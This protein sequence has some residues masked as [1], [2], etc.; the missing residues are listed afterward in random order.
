MDTEKRKKRLTRLIDRMNDGQ[1]AALRDMRS[2]LLD[3]QFN[4]FQSEWDAQLEQRGE[5]KAKPEAVAEY[6]ERFKAA[7]FAYN[8]A[9]GYSSSARRNPKKGNDGLFTHQRLYAESQTLFEKLVE[10]LS[11]QLDFDPQLQIWFDRPLHDLNVGLTPDDVP[12]VVTSR[13]LDRTGNGF[14][15]ANLSKRDIKLRALNDSLAALVE[16]ERL[17]KRTPAEVAAEALV[18][19]EN[20]RR[21]AGLRSFGRQR[22]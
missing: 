11:E 3:E 6:E 16:V 18:A 13:S 19:S 1:D 20:L 7:Q 4:A 10:Y 9:E 14:L 22:K 8:K 15:I 21:A 17:A 12:R 2:A 5:V